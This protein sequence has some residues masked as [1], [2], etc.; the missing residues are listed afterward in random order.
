MEEFEGRTRLVTAA[1]SAG[2]RA[3]AQ[4]PAGEVADAATGRPRAHGRGG[5]AAAGGVR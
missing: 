3:L 1:A 5:A 2:G 4:R